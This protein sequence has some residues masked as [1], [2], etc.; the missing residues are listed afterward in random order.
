MLAKMLGTMIVVEAGRVSMILSRG[1]R[2]RVI[3]TGH[4]R[5]LSRSA[6]SWQITFI[7]DKV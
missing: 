3:A 6:I 2:S 5:R 4:Y 1:Q 7:Y